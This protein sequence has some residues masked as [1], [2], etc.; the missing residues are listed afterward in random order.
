MITRVPNTPTPIGCLVGFFGLFTA[1][2]SL[3]AFWG[4]FKAF[5]QTPPETEVGWTLVRWGAVAALPALAGIAFCVYRI[6]TAG[7]REYH[8]AGQSLS[9]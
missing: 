1:L 5:G 2:F 8:R 3:L 9:T 7:K 6:A 4:A